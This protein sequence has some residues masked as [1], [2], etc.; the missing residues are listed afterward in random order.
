MS[1]SLGEPSQSGTKGIKFFKGR[2]NA[3][4]AASRE[5][6]SLDLVPHT[7]FEARFSTQQLLPATSASSAAANSQ[8]IHP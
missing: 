7:E 8:V 5:A 6:K 4:Q 3:H 1:L 2:D